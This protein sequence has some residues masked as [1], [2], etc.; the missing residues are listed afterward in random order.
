MFKTSKIGKSAIL[1]V[2]SCAAILLFILVPAF[3]GIASDRLLVPAASASAMPTPETPVY[4]GYK[5]V[6]IGMPMDQARAKLGTARDK[7][8][9]E[10]YYVIS[11]NETVQVQFDADK[12]VR[13]IAVNFIGNNPSAPAAKAVF[14]SDAEIRPDGGA[15]K[16]V[17]YPKAGY[18]VSYIKTAGENAM[19][20]VTIQR[21]PTAPVASN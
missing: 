20:I 14:G 1:P 8:D 15:F 18:W 4:T 21:I 5:N 10:D 13:T 2:L 11:E 16:M 19:V 3:L 12:K 9:A 6:T 17:R 7:S